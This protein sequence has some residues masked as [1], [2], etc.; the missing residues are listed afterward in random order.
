M[1]AHEI[2]RLKAAAEAEEELE[3]EEEE[4]AARGMGGGRRRA[5]GDGLGGGIRSGWWVEKGR[6]RWSVCG[7]ERRGDFEME[8][9][10]ED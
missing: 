3:K 2:A 4:E 9:I 7:A 5:S 6:K 8:T 10:W 1:E